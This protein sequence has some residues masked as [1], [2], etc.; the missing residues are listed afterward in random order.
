M[1]KKIMV[2]ILSVF[3]MTTVL[4][5]C[6]GPKEID[7]PAGKVTVDEG[8][9]GP[10]WCKTGMKVTSSD[11][12]GQQGSFEIKGLTQHNGTE[13]CEAE[14]VHE[15]G[16]LTQYFNEKGDY[17]V[18]IYKDKSGKVIQEV[19]MVNPNPNNK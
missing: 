14:I 5:G 9:T 18:M 3:I 2:T 8:R 19:N 6:T 10:D 16:T 17:I 7:T 11:Q 12:Q 15:E 13:V 1:N 4:S